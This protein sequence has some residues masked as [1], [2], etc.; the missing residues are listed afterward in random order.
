MCQSNAFMRTLTEMGV[1]AH[2]TVN[3][4][5]M[6]RVGGVMN[7]SAASSAPIAAMGR[8][9]LLSQGNTTD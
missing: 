5:R 3:V 7:G 9:R 6:V 4:T 1:F 8:R 2:F